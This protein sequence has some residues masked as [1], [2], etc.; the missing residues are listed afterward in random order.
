MSLWPG[1]LTLQKDTQILQSDIH[2]TALGLWQME[3]AVFLVYS[4]IAWKGYMPLER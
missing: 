3:V 4:V 2:G 1:D